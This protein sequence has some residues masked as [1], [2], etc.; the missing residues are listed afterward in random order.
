[1]KLVLLVLS[2]L[3]TGT[4]VFS[5]RISFNL[6]GTP[7]SGYYEEIPYELVYGK[8]ILSVEIDGR[9][10]RF[11][12]DTGAPT[13]ISDS[14]AAELNASAL[15]RMQV[16]DATGKRDSLLVVSLREIHLGGLVFTGIPALRFLPNV[17]RC[18]HLDGAVGSNMLRG[19]IVQILPERHVIILTDD[20]RRLSQKNRN[21]IPMGTNRDQ[22]SYPHI[23]VVFRSDKININVDLGFDT[24]G[25]EFLALSDDYARQVIQQYHVCSIVQRG[26]GSDKISEFGAA[27][28]DSTYR[29]L[30]PRFTVAQ[31]MFDSL[32]T[33]TQKQ[34]I[35]RIGRKLL[36]YGSVTLDFIHGKFY[37]EPTS[38][39][40]HL[41]EPLWPFNPIII[42]NKLWV[43][44]VW[45]ASAALKPGE[46]I[47]GIGAVGLPAIDACTWFGGKYLDG[48][49][50]VVLKVGN[51]DAVREVRVVKNRVGNG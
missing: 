19:S 22:Q 28:S 10:H 18:L 14:L 26:F 41:S 23:N 49:Q 8:M 20:L 40:N 4:S 24:G 43:G 21:S 47:V 29:V 1:M 48:L 16:T 38:A 31:A 17:L 42:D 6:G 25:N 39:D 7:S 3:L 2:A 34:G 5:Q 13:C 50:E 33:E 15:G 32:V 46:Q 12:F 45:D 30:V 27:A 9:K 11:L 36:D 35:S 37:F 44:V 51:G